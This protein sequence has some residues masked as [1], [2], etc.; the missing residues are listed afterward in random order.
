MAASGV[1]GAPITL[2]VLLY[3]KDNLC[4]DTVNFQEYQMVEDLM[5]M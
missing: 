2:N 1:C 4:C 5:Q 3:S